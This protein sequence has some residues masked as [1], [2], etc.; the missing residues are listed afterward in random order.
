M[1]EPRFRHPEAIVT[2]EWL[3]ANLADP[4]LRVFDCTSYLAAEP[5][6]GRL[7]VVSGRADYDA[8]HIPGSG[9][10]DIQGQL[11]DTTG[12]YRF[13]MLAAEEFAN[14]IGRLGVGNGLRVVLYSRASPVWATRVW[15]MLRAVGF[16]AAAILDGG[17]DKW[18]G[19]GRAASAEPRDHPPQTLTPKPRPELFVGAEAV[20][21]AIGEAG[22]CTIN[23]L[24]PDRHSGEAS[25]YGRP[26]RIAGS[27]N[28]PAGA[29]LNPATQEFLSPDTVAA[30]FAAVGAAPA[31][32]TIVYCGG[33]IAATLDAFLLHQ[34]GFEDIAVYD[35]SMSE[36][37]TDERRPMETG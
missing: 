14:R 3:E 35:N 21:G 8:A 25:P 5:G 17:W 28:V 1:G 19:E 37:A 7:Y 4:A 32:R 16:D 26:G 29:L 12:P 30:A 33:G 15:W 22:V 6:T 10:L 20:Q 13:T 27:V 18:H 2:T 24:A 23:A 36:W 31:K 11:S 34:L 9:F